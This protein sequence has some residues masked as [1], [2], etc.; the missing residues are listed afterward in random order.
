MNDFLPKSIAFSKLI[1]V[2]FAN[3]YCNFEINDNN[4]KNTALFTTMKKFFFLSILL[5]QCVV[6]AQKKVFSIKWGA[7]EQYSTERFSYSVPGFQP[8]ENYV[9][10]AISGVRFVSEWTA[11]GEVNENSATLSGIK[12]QSLSEKELLDLDKTAIPKKLT[13]SLK[14]TRARNKQNVTFTLYPIVKIGSK[15][16]RVTSFTLN[17]KYGSNAKKKQAFKGVVTS[18]LENGDWYRF[19]V[20]KS[21]VFKLSKS[22]LNSIGVKT[23][24]L[25]PKTIRIFGTGGHMLPYA[26]S[27]NTLIDPKELPIKVIG[28]EDG[29]FDKDDYVLFYAEGP[30]FFNENGKTNK[31]NYT[32]STF[33]YLNVGQ[34]TGKRIQPMVQPTQAPDTL[35]TTFQDYKFHEIDDYNLANLGRRWFGDRFD[36]ETTKSFNFNF[37]NLVTSQSVQLRVLVASTSQSVTSFD[38]DV[39]GANQGSVLISSLSDKSMAEGG[40]LIRQLNVL[41]DDINVT[42]NYDKKG[43]PSA[44]G[45]LDYI[46]VEAT[47]KLV[48]SNKQLEFKGDVTKAKTGVAEYQLSNTKEISE[49]WDVTSVFDV[50]E[51]KTNGA[52]SISL[53]APLGSLK[54]FVAVASGDYYEPLSGTGVVNQSLKSA[55]FSDENGNFKD[56]DYLILTKAGHLAQ[57]ERLAKINRAKNGLNVKV[58]TDESI[59]NEFSTGNPDIVAIRNFIKYVYDN[60]SSPEK[61][62]KYVCLFGDGSVDYKGRAKFKEF[63]Y[64]FPSW[65]SVNSFRLDGSYVSDDFYGL[66]D[67]DEGE[68]SPYEKLDIAIGRIIANS[69]T[70][71]KIA[72]DKI[73]RYYSKKSYGSWRNNFVVI[74]DDVD[75]GWEDIIQK[76]TNKIADEVEAEKPFIN[77]TKIHADAYKQES[78]SGGD[79]YPEVTQ[80]ISNAMESGALVVNYFGHGGED[81]LAKERIFQKPDV[82][83]LRNAYKMNCL[84]TVTCEYTRFDNPFRVTAG[85]LMFWNKDGGAV[86]LITTIRQIGVGVGTNINEELGKYL[87]SYVDGDSYEDDE[88]PSIA[89]AVRLTKNDKKVG[90]NNQR[91]FMIFVGDPA[92]KLAIPKPDIKLTKINNVPIEKVTD[93]LKALSYVKLSGEVTTP[94]GTLMNSY[95][96]VLTSTIYD[97]Y[98]ERETLAN[99]NVV[100]SGQVYK[101]KFKTLGPVIYRGKASVKNGK[102]EFDFVVPK[103]INLSKGKGKL[104]FYSVVNDFTEDQTG[105]NTSNLY[106]GG[107]NKDAPEDNKGP[108][109]SLFMN[110]ENFVSGG[111]TNESPTLLVN[112]EDEN[113]IN[114]ASGIGH[115]IVALIDGDEVNPF[116]LNEYYTTE[117]DNYKKGS[118]SYPFRNLKPGLHTLT[119]K[120]WDVYNNSSTAEIQFMVYNENESLVLDNVLNYPNPFINYT[121][122]WFNHNSSEVLDVSVQI[123][124]VSGKLIRTIKSQTSG[125]GGGNVKA[126]SKDVVWDGRDD[127]G[128]KIGKGTYIYKLKVYSKTTNK[129]AEKIEK[130]VIL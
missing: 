80:A 53:K 124:T 87:F 33:Y 127:F 76:T 109:I 43:N 41:E 113:G 24:G 27:E 118:L 26:N 120:A 48:F 56:V 46:S 50:S 102:F 1:T 122:F 95:N 84:V 97:K 115:D 29:A 7:P 2:A 67:D 81:G 25:D 39:N 9:Y 82:N 64:E 23:D 35:I 52:E 78:S 103:D 88:Y 94:T 47:R 62:L 57:A 4:I 20:D 12:Y 22:F 75:K 60:A 31:N 93:T 74:S 68:M 54:T 44:Q 106:I 11:K 17:Y 112:L 36:I 19:N 116:V 128:E 42:L 126:L 32:D 66:L 6:F 79:R 72:V 85:E 101:M 108:L 8:K 21:G 111:V 55:V 107:I 40:E 125:L 129:S 63:P 18:V 71:G 105:A 61:R 92:M 5:F 90:N 73:E 30:H 10:D 28:E 51:L 45:Y 83:A 70:Q 59:Y 130:L 58:V 114:T 37:P 100:I 110:D 77:V 3:Y 34:T 119:L 86:S 69:Q 16:K 89:E 14:N 15:Y 121:E 123:F 104:S 117:I 38:V 65:Y 13:Y 99:D 98:V 49:I 96:G 91:R